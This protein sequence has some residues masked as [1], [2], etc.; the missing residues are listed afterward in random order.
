MYLFLSFCTTKD[1][2]TFFNSFFS[3][4][5]DFHH[6]KEVSV[7]CIAKFSMCH[8]T[9]VQRVEGGGWKRSSSFQNTGLE[10]RLYQRQLAT[11][12]LLT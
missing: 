8:V 12:S 4:S 2:V 10:A 11:C 5:T 3:V 1:F 9:V 7:F 6:H